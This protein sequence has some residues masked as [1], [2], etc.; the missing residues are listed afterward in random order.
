MAFTTGG[1]SRNF[2]FIMK[3]SN[4]SLLRVHLSSPKKGFAGS[5]E[6]VSQSHEISHRQ[7]NEEEAT[8]F[9]SKVEKKLVHPIPLTC[10]PQHTWVIVM[11]LSGM[12]TH[13]VKSLQPMHLSYAPL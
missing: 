10:S 7:L 6:G 4:I 12:P 1:F 8:K 5:Q 2:L 11:M 9:Q 3:S 13:T